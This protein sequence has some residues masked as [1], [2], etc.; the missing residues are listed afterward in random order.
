L[1]LRVKLTQQHVIFNNFEQE[2][3]SLCDLKG[4]VFDEN[5]GSDDPEV[6]G[7]LR[8]FILETTSVHVHAFHE[9]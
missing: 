2:K 9:D 7:E 5:L 6:T 1:N 4:L 8:L 3:N